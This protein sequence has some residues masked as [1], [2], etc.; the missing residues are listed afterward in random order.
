[1]WWM[2]DVGDR[3]SGATAAWARPGSG[4]SGAR[5][6]SG[7]L[8][9]R[10]ICPP[11]HRAQIT[12]GHIWRSPA[13]APV[14]VTAGPSHQSG[15]L[16]SPGHRDP[17]THACFVCRALPS[18][19]LL[20]SLRAMGGPRCSH[21]FGPWATLDGHMRL[22]LCDAEWVGERRPRPTHRPPLWQP[23]DLKQDL[24]HTLWYGPATPTPLGVRPT[25]TTAPNPGMTSP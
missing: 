1:M 3:P 6:P 11:A 21:P 25:T 18:G 9:P 20:T 4:D 12:A 8:E 14:S 13:S 5:Q 24:R 15:C 17:G 19:C 2:W 22:G 16:S 7:P 10:T 23:P